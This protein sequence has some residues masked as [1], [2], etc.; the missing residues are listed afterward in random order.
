M[1]DSHEAP[2]TR[3]DSWK[4]ISDYLGRDE[5]TV[6][7]WEKEQGLPVRR[8]PGGR[9]HS[10]FAYV[11]EIEAWLQTNSPVRAAQ[12]P[13]DERHAAGAPDTLA[14]TPV[15]LPWRRAR[16]FAIAAVVLAL[17][18][19]A[20]RSLASER[21]S[22]PLRLTM[23]TTGILASDVTGDEVWRY[24][25]P[26]SERVGLAETTA[27]MVPTSVRGQGF[28]ALQG[29]R[30]RV[31]DNVTLSGQL[32]WLGSDGR[33]RREVSIDD[34][35]QFGRERYGAPW[36]VIEGRLDD[37]GT[38]GRLAITAHHYT[39]WPGIVAIFDGELRRLGTF[40]NAGWVEGVRW[41]G[42]DRIIASGFSNDRN[43]GMV[44]LLD[45]NSLDGQS[46]EVADPRFHCD[47]CGSGAPI[48]YVVLPRSELNVV[49]GAAFNRA[50]LDV[51]SGTVMIRTDEIV[52]PDGS[53][54]DAI[55]EFNA[56]LD[57]ANASYS[58]RYWDVHRAL[59]AQGK[60][61]HT[62]E[63][64][65]DRNGPR[66]IQVWEPVTGWRTVRVQRN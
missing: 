13:R 51:L 25:F 12:S 49:T 14:L 3:L 30:V 55:Y 11:A 50:R 43:G 33:L 59:E 5:R 66:E 23:T 26:L 16:T 41:V 18:V 61:H 9:G 37:R 46:P 42:T 53:I 32:L 45:A 2:A 54:A 64:C 8:V 24:P 36:S 39:W 17:S 27:V 6:R 15:P 31:S 47:T 7:R 1:T 20:W 19:T 63:Q 21:S 48:R 35:L 28:Y 60:I 62:R 29:Q 52:E 10:V 38:S 56:T 58:D 44:A 65:P 22:A 34:S 40:V 4:A 57:V